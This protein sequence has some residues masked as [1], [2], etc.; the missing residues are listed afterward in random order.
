MEILGGCDSAVDSQAGLDGLNA[1]PP[2]VSS[3]DRYFVS[4]P[5]PHGT[6]RV[7]GS[8]SEGTGSPQGLLAHSAR[9]SADYVTQVQ[10]NMY[11]EVFPALCD[12][13]VT[14]SSSAGVD[15]RFELSLR[16][17]SNEPAAQHFQGIHSQEHVPSSSSAGPDAQLSIPVVQ[18]SQAKNKVQCTRSGCSTLVNKDNL[19]RHVNEVHEGK[20]KAVCAGCRKEF[21]RP[22]QMN[23]HILRTRCGT[24]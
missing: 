16:G 17:T 14:E 3:H 10:H 11:S 8:L 7:M 24:S 22:Y 19:T 4:Q 1:I 9:S 21:K 13:R 23:Q 18:A 15:A 2:F 12:P 6:F 20:I 5:A